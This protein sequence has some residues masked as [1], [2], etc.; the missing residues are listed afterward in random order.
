MEWLISRCGLHDTTGTAD[1]S[2]TIPGS[3][4]RA[5]I[6]LLLYL[7]P[8]TFFEARLW[9][10]RLWPQPCRRQ[11]ILR[12]IL[13]GPNGVESGRNGIRL[14]W[15]QA[16]ERSAPIC[17]ENVRLY[18]YREYYLKTLATIYTRYYNKEL[19][20]LLETSMMVTFISCAANFGRY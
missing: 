3:I 6:S 7:L 1:C 9:W 17:H 19:R 2:R 18:S 10:L 16:A 11:H 14:A 5:M 20:I 4:P 12:A 13:E 8:G 15:D